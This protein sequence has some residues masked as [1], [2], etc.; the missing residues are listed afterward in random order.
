MN[1]VAISSNGDFVIPR[2][3]RTVYDFL[4]DPLRFAPMLPD[5]ENVEVGEDQNFVVKLKVGVS[6]HPGSGTYRR[7]P[8]W[9]AITV[10]RVD[11]AER[12]LTT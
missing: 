11:E 8:F 9:N 3:C 5:F 2:K 7:A 12:T 6:Q 10:D 4:S 1:P